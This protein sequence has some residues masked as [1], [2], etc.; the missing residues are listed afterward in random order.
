MPCSP[1]SPLHSGRGGGGYL[2][3]E[4][5]A[6]AFNLGR[7]GRGGLFILPAW[8]EI[9]TSDGASWADTVTPA[10]GDPAGFKSGFNSGGWVGLGHG[11]RQW[12]G[13]G[14]LSMGGV[15]SGG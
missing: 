14:L 2:E 9:G 6:Q 4:Q 13:E 1:A 8:A 7:G 12:F 3:G 10:R 5:A 15:D 11:Q